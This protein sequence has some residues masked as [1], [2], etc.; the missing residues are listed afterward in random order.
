[1]KAIKVAL[2]VALL[3]MGISQAQN[4]VNILRLSGTDA[5]PAWFDSIA[6]KFTE[7]T[8]IPVVVEELENEDF[9]KKL[10][11]LLQTSEAPHVFYS[12]GGG[13]YYEQAASGATRNVTSLMGEDFL[14]TQ[15]AAGMNAFTIDEQIMGVPFKVS[16]VGI[17]YN[18]AL[19]EQAGV[20]VSTIATWDDFLAAV[21]QVKDAG[22]TPIALGGADK[23]P[24]HFYW[25]YL[26]MRIAGQEGLSAARAG[27]ASFADEP[28]IQAGEEL[29]RLVDLEPFQEGFSAAT[30][31]DASAFFGNGNAAF[32]VM[33]DWEIG[34]QSSQSEDGLGLEDDLGFFNFPVVEGGAGRAT[35][36]LGGFDGFAFSK[37]APDEA[38]QFMQYFLSP[39]NQ[40]EAG[41]QDLYIPIVKGSDAGIENAIRAQISRNVA[42]SQW[43]QLFLDQDLGADVGGV[44]NDISLQ[45]ATGDIDP[46]GAAELIQEAWELR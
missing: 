4:T 43:H 19:V 46:Q 20:D 34:A 18:K 22:I 33:G 37:D 8:G 12:W 13:V 35:D 6:A 16:Q 42:E 41:A 32:H 28:F 17:F 26:A 23:W 27:E 11:T 44:V 15:S 39:E 14:A 45:L 30:Y 1:V 7:E 40:L 5:F 24:V 38:V 25:S 36:T 10:P 31:N 2:F 3:L 9:K 29:K 21:Q